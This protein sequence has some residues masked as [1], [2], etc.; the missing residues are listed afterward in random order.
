MTDRS[1]DITIVGLGPGPAALRTMAVQRAL[2]VARHIYVRNH[3]GT[4]F[5][6]LL[7]LPNVTDVASLRDPSA[8]SG[9]RW[10]ASARAVVDDAKNG[11]VVLAIPG[12][13]SFGEMLT[14]ETM[15]EADARGL[16]V[17]IL[18]GVSMI[19][20]L[21]TALE[22]DAVRERVQLMDGR[23]IS[24]LQQHAPF[25]GGR[26][27][28]TPRFPMLITHVYD[29][30]ITRPLTEQLLRILPPEHA[31]TL[32]SGAGLPSESRERLAL[33]DLAN[34]PGGPMLAIYVP[35]LPEL[36]AGRD[37]RTLQHIVARLRAPDGCPWDRKQTNATL[38]DALVDE[39]YEA[40][41]AINAGDSENF[42]EELGD[43]F[44][45]VAM[46]AQIAEEAGQF[47]L[48]DVYEGIARKIVRRHPHVFGDEEAE[49]ATDV[50]TVWQKVKAEEKANSGRSRSTKA[51][52]G[53]PHSMPALERATR[54]L[55][56]HPLDGHPSG[57]AS[58]G[59][60]LL[61]E[62]AGIIDAGEDPDA[63]LRAALERHVATSDRDDR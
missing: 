33:A 11:P 29:N 32:V 40:V 56:K 25:D 17:E 15:R 8:P 60:R 20:L 61:A 27:T 57:N 7:D 62:I 22:L 42:A 50:S 48:E 9:Q 24:F 58:S 55:R 41:D 45:L 13:A 28:A 54:V 19:D 34:H 39:V 14:V 1:P 3:P 10:L 6:D 36:D 51:G 31:L 44:L 46:H 59:E 30:E 52:D 16:R 43:I 18:D 35:P 5:A 23:S 37:P 26:F 49:N 47:T 2:D 63:V 12:H 21:C 53:Q 4:D 38:R